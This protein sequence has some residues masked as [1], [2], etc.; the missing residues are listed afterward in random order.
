M[1]ILSLRRSSFLVVGF[2]LLLGACSTATTRT[3]P[4][5]GRRPQETPVAQPTTAAPKPQPPQGAQVFALPDSQVAPLEPVPV[6]GPVPGAIDSPP[7]TSHAIKPPL[8]PALRELVAQ[9][10]RASARGDR[11]AARATLERA[12]K[13]TPE[14]A[15]LWFRLAEL[16]FVDGEYEQAIVMA[17]RARELARGERELIYQ[18][19]QLI[20]RARSSLTR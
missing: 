4:I 6:P 8:D 9:A 20:E 14:N 18:A 15:Q 16:N 12:L 11:G 10:E 3:A 13:I 5:E 2:A 1:K 7:A 19:D 17:Q